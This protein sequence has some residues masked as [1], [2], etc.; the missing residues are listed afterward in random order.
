MVKN[1]IC[2]FIV[3]VKGRPCL[4]LAFNFTLGIVKP[5]TL[6][7]PISRACEVV[8]VK[9]YPSNPLSWK[10]LGFQCCSSRSFAFCAWM[11]F[12]CLIQSI[13]DTA[14]VIGNHTLTLKWVKGIFLLVAFIRYPTLECPLPTPL[15][16]SAEL[17]FTLRRKPPFIT[18]SQGQR[19]WEL[20]LP[21]W[22]QTWAVNCQKKFDR[23]RLWLTAFVFA[24]PP[25]S[26]TSLIL[27]RNV[28]SEW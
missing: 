6:V 25:V 11:I 7:V 17:C 24:C 19:V 26:L 10:D 14:N 9:S 3:L 4:Y 22:E 20:V 18:C 27:E 1:C 2:F 28:F 5:R 8:P 12:F 13:F 23:G 15:Q 21:V 16:C